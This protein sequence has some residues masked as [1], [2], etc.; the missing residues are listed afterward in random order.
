M[1]DFIIALICSVIVFCVLFPEQIQQGIK[2]IIK[3]IIDWA[4]NGR[5]KPDSISVLL[6]VFLLLCCLAF[7]IG[8]FAL[9]STFLPYMFNTPPHIIAA[10]IL[11]AAATG[12]LAHKTEG[13]V[14]LIIIA[15][16]V[17]FILLLSWTAYSY[18]Q[19]QGG[20]GLSL[21]MIVAV[22]STMEVMIVY[23]LITKFEDSLAFTWLIPISIILIPIYLL[24]W[25]MGLARYLPERIHSFIED[26]KEILNKRKLAQS[27]FKEELLQEDLKEQQRKTI[28]LITDRFNYSIRTIKA[29]R[30]KAIRKCHSTV[31]ITIRIYH[32]F[33]CLFRGKKNA[34]RVYDSIVEDFTL[35]QLDKDVQHIKENKAKSNGKP[36][37]FSYTMPLS[38]L[39]V[40]IGISSFYSIAIGQELNNRLFI[41]HRDVTQSFHYIEESD[42]HI[43]QAVI[44][45][46]GFNDNIVI[47]SLGNFSQDSNLQI[48]FPLINSNIN[49]RR[50]SFPEWK[51]DN[52]SFQEEW[53]SV[54]M[55]KAQIIK[56]L[57]EPTLQQ[58][59]GFT[60]LHDMM[61]YSSIQFSQFSGK[62]FYFVYS[63]L[64]NEKNRE[65]KTRKPPMQVYD[66][67]NVNV[68]FLFVEF[69]DYGEWVSIKR[70]WEDY[71]KKTNAHSFKIY[72]VS[73]SKMA[74][75]IIPENP[76]PKNLPEFKPKE[77]KLW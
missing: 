41:I 43:A 46:L 7:M 59:G 60:E 72:D 27:K 51:K 75:D 58:Q 30:L 64:L 76:I 73:S 23:C 11:G 47:A 74:L 28:K 38:I 34:E 17:L 71:F 57:E 29:V 24:A 12:I 26:F 52:E 55:L 2:K 16:I 45:R 21:A 22:V 48:N 13:R 10:M 25:L 35:P 61:A 40:L 70:E 33:L 77:F 53:S 1:F 20:S 19:I 9:L 68:F 4:S 39:I 49:K 65:E 15:L 3:D 54:D 5:A 14:Q 36:E 67:T 69:K 37:S 6:A 62:K 31:L 50:T 66:F 8:N 63:D 32:F 44:P 56:W 18:A 42:C